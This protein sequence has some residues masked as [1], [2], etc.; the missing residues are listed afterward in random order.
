VAWQIRISL[1]A[2]LFGTRSAKP[3]NYRRTTE[4]T[5]RREQEIAPPWSR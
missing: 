3:L 2:E 5:I 4:A 1:E